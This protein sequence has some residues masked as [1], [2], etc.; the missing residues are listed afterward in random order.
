[1]QLSKTLRSTPIFLTG[2]RAALAPVMLVVALSG[3]SRIQFGVCLVA[4]FLSDIFDGVLARRLNV[5][6]PAL[7]RL[8]SAADTL[9]YLAALYSAWHLYPHAIESRR[10]ALIGLVV[11][12]VVRYA[13]DW[14]KF[15]RE[16]S[17]HMWSSKLWGIVL[18]IAF[19]ALLAF[20]SDNATMSV[21]LYMGILAD[22][23]G[24]AISITLRE[25][26]SDVPTLLHAIALR[27][28]ASRS[29]QFA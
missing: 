16:A 28:A 19:V 21:A 6:T 2:I 15:R 26:K 23:E 3:G 9:F 12:E 20:G 4:A 29:A 17:Y 18:F 5:A 14:L 11:L 25:W 8:D 24:L 7:R 22:L 10:T 13:F 1:M 27:R